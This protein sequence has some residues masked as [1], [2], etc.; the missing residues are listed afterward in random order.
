MTMTPPD[1]FRTALS[2]GTPDRVPTLPKIWV[3]LAAALTG[4]D[5]ISA[6]EDPLLAA[7]IVV[8]AAID[9]GADAARLFHF[10]PRKTRLEDGIVVEIDARGRTLGPIDMEGG[11]ATQLVDE[12]TLPLEDPFRMAFLSAWT[13]PRPLVK[14]LADVDRIAV[15]D[16]TF[17]EQAGCADRQRQILA[18]AADRIALA[19]D[20]GSATLAFSVLVRNMNNALVDL[21]EE[22]RLVDAI[23]D[24]GMAIVIEKGKFFIDNG[25]NIL[26]LNDSVA[27]MSVI[28]PRA[29]RRFIGP[30]FK[31]ICDELH[32]YAPEAM[33][34]CHICGNVQPVIE[35]LVETGLDCIGPLDPLGGLDCARVRELAGGRI[36][37][38]GGVNTLLFASDRTDRIADETGRCI[39]AAGAGGAFIVGSGCALPR[40]SRR[41]NL[42]AFRRA[43]EIHGTYDEDGN[44]LPPA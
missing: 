7:R 44:L 37:L 19:G 35:D 41:R 6:I 8:E 33:V 15:P 1:R 11:L 9:V 31:M 17:Y 5:P 21:I 10:P 22:P 32:G 26:R 12:Y 27:N 36:A 2:G 28:S 25:V 38:M 13:S 30:R 42:A 24:K 20:L 4:T 29:W 40:N 3:D 18:L 16:K 39:R 23:M 34:Y 43:A 14:N